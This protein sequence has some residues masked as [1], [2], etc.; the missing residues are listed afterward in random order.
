VNPSLAGPDITERKQAEDK[1][2]SSMPSLNNA[3]HDRTTQ[4][5]AANQDWKLLPIRFRTICGPFTRD[6]WL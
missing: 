3:F 6:P 5:E 1:F 2:A 4:L